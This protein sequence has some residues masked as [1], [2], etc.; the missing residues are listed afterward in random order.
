MVG[1]IG[2]AAAVGHLV[3]GPARDRE[4]ARRALAVRELE[5]VAG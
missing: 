5:R 1:A 4:A 3:T 2:L